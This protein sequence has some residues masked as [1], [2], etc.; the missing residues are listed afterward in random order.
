[1]LRAEDLFVHQTPAAEA[2]EAAGAAKTA[3]A[4][5]PTKGPFFQFISHLNFTPL[6]GKNV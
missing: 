2:A 5:Q 1:M 6:S 3:G 4:A